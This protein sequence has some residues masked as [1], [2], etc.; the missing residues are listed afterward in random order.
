LFSPPPPPP[1]PPLS[2]Y[3]TPAGF[4]WE[5]GVT[6]NLPEGDGPEPIVVNPPSPFTENN[7]LE[8]ATKYVDIAKTR[9]AYF[10]TNNILMLS[11]CDFSKI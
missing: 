1:S 11:G 9:A 7:E 2:S 10:K 3:C 4:D 5:H 8:I 6:Q